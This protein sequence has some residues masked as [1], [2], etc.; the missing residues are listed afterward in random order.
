MFQLFH[1]LGLN[2]VKK[3][4]GKE[5]SKTDFLTINSP[6]PGKRGVSPKSSKNEN[7]FGETRRLPEAVQTTVTLPK[8][9]G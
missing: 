9:L 1:G 4:M 2:S 8:A 7:H 5:R 6:V 3:K